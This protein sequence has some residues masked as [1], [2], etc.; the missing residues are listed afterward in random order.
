MNEWQSELGPV[1]HHFH[2][3]LS[4]AEFLHTDDV[5][6]DPDDSISF[7]CLY[8]LPG[9]FNYFGNS[10]RSEFDGALSW[11]NGSQFG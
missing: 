6:N 4:L 2:V 10:Y 11:K 9:W 8:L 5:I 7:I 3:D 1:I